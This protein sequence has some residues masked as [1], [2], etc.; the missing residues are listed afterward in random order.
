MVQRSK[1]VES[2]KKLAG[3]KGPKIEFKLGQPP[4]YKPAYCEKVVKLAAQGR[5]MEEIAWELRVSKKTLYNWQERYEE[6]AYALEMMDTAFDSWFMKVGRHIIE[7]TLPDNRKGNASLWYSWAKNKYSWADKVENY[8]ENA[9]IEFVLYAG[10]EEL[11]KD[12][13]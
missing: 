8:N 4:K 6:F 9:P 2:A 7:D 11:I 12:D 10:E 13:V 5:T 1:M 3:K